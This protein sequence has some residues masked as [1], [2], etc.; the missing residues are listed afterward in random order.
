MAG[1]G[2]SSDISC[3]SGGNSAAAGA[4]HSS[5]PPPAS[6]LHSTC[7]GSSPGKAIRLIA[8]SRRPRM[9][10]ERA[11]RHAAAR[12][13]APVEIA[14]TPLPDPDG[15]EA[16]V[17]LGDLRDRLA[18]VLN[19]LAKRRPGP[20]AGRPAIP[21]PRRPGGGAGGPPDARSTPSPGSVPQGAGWERAV[22]SAE[23]EQVVVGVVPLARRRRPGQVGT[24]AALTGS[25]PRPGTRGAAGRRPDSVSG[26][27]SGRTPSRRTSRSGRR[28]A[29]RETLQTVQPAPQEKRRRPAQR[30][31]T[32]VRA[33]RPRRCRSGRRAGSGSPGWWTCEQV[34]PR[35]VRPATAYER[36]AEVLA[37]AVAFVVAESPAVPDVAE[38]ADG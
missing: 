36:G 31:G 3:P 2:Q 37:G 10:K 20:R 33:G 4:P 34:Q 24:A 30:P 8:G 32:G 11:A 18:E 38:L 15:V 29:Q 28:P 22:L 23:G 6:S 9:S 16:L 5:V 26:S 21:R 35:V 1:S 7:G 14:G 17:E 13:C 27:V 12:A 25:G 19:V